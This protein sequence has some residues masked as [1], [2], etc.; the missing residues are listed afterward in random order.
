MVGGRTVHGIVAAAAVLAGV[1]SSLCGCAPVNCPAVKIDDN[2]L[3]VARSAS[4]PDLLMALCDGDDCTDAIN[5]SSPEDS[6]ER[7]GALDLYPAKVGTWRVGV[8][9]GSDP[10]SVT[11]KLSTATALLATKRLA[12][13]WHP[14]SGSCSSYS[15]AD[16]VHISLP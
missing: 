14:A 7:A 10:S 8:F 16:D 1:L 4:H 12:I 6:R 13:S 15:T 3:I 11:V 5:T 2:F 9:S